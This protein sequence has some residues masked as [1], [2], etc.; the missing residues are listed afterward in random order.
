MKSES[1]NVTNTMPTNVTNTVSINF[2][3]NE[4]RYKIDYYILYTLMLVTPWLFL[5]A[6]ICYYY[7]KYRSKRKII[8]NLT[9]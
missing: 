7:A 1:T 3:D 4:V 8:G 2:G 6:I 9:T 5:I